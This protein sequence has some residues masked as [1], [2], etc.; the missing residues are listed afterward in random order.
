MKKNFLFLVFIFISKL[1][2]SQEVS[3]SGNI[4]TSYGIFAP[5]TQNSGDFSFGTTNFT[6]GLE[7]YFDKSSAFFEGKIGY[8]FAESKILFDVNEAFVDFA[9]SFWGFRFGRQKIAF[10]KADGINITNSVFPENSSSLFLEDSSLGIDGL[11]LSFFGNSFMIDAFWIPFFKATKLP[12]DESNI[13]KKY[14]VPNSIEYEIPGLGSQTIELNL[15]KFESP[16][17]KIKN[18]EYAL[19]ISGYFPICD[20]SFYGFYGWD[21]TPMLNGKIVE[22]KESSSIPTKVNVSGEY[23]KLTMIGLDTAFPIKEIVLRA[24]TAFFPNRYQ[25]TSYEYILKNQISS[26]EKN[27][28][29]ALCGIDWMPSTWTITAQYFGDYIFGS[30]ENL[31]RNKNYTHGA[32]FS[33]SKTFFNDES[34]ELSLASLINFPDFDFVIN[35]NTNYSLSDEIKLKFGTYIFS[36]GLKSDGT[37]GLYKNL[38][39]FFVSAEY[40]F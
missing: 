32:S 17:L 9:S 19:K 30:L 35:L 12:L 5:W 14:I 36:P 39:T 20:I 28:I 23:K 13:L 25:Q 21:K 37:Y 3:F 40:K 16:E 38:S 18:S 29:I 8:N 2:F 11:R 31:Q 33:I 10:G 27:Q 1:V 34:L 22:T 6:G 7:A 24:E 15:G 26:V 4:N